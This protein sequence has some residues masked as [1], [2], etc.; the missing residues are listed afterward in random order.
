MEIR[1]DMIKKIK[2][3][4]ISVSDKSNLKPLLQALKKN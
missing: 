4:L 2:T 1:K 3:A